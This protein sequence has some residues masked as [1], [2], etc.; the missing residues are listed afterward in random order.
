L[1]FDG[2]CRERGR[3]LIFK[4]ARVTAGVFPHE[5]GPLS[6]P[7][8]MFPR[9]V[10]SIPSGDH[11]IVA[12]PATVLM[13]NGFAPPLDSAVWYALSDEV[14]FELISSVDRELSPAR[15]F[16]FAEA[17]PPA[18]TLIEE[19]LLLTAIRSGAIVDQQEIE[20]RIIAILRAVLRAAYAQ[21]G[22]RGLTPREI[23]GI[24]AVRD[25]IGHN[26]ADNPSLAELGLRAGMSRTQLCRLF[27]RRT[28]LG[29]TRFGHVLRGCLAIDIMTRDV[30]PLAEIAARLGYSSHGHFTRTFK[31]IFGETPSD[32]RKR[33]AIAQYA[34]GDL[35]ERSQCS[36]GDPGLCT[37]K[38]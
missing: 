22:P 21:K 30:V 23:E 4:S 33:F 12:T 25:W 14:L 18:R 15:P 10:G 6:Q 35:Q 16:R 17:A 38:Q 26:P 32:V 34:Y 37:H 1:I 3:V 11:R 29:L 27:P 28:G 24:E 2:P 31:A 36:G 7:T 9:A 19:R 8:F 20:Q 5:E 13:H